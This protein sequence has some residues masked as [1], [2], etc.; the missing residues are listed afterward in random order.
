MRFQCLLACLLSWHVLSAWPYRSL[1]RPPPFL[2]RRGPL[3]LS[4]PSASLATESTSAQPPQHGVRPTSNETSDVSTI[5]SSPLGAVG[6]FGFRQSSQL[7]AKASAAL[8]SVTAPAVAVAAAATTPLPV[9]LSKELGLMRARVDRLERSLAERQL[10]VGGR[11]K[12]TGATASIDA[13]V[14]TINV[15]YLA[16]NAQTVEVMSVVGCFVVGAIVSASLLDRLW[17]V[18]GAVAGYWASGA[19]HR[20]SRGGLVARR[21]GVQ[22]TQLVRDLQEKTMQFMLFYRTGQVRL[23]CFPWT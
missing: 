7:L 2:S 14:D 10:V 20:D 4:E 1:S 5:L 18:G 9:G 23:L 16:M 15:N 21:V 12:K 19:V 6:E 17:L 11:A 13:L 8:A 22:L 3:R